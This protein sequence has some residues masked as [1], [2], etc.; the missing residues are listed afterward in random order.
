[1]NIYG[2]PSSL[3]FDQQNIFCGLFYDAII[4][5]IMQRRTVGWLTNEELDS[6]RKAR[7]VASRGIVSAFVCRDSG[8]LWKPSIRIY[9]ISNGILV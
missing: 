4:L 6:V 9:G 3:K 2:Y 5:N 1:M 7:A 8:E